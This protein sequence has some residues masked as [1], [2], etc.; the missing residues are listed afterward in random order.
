MRSTLSAVLLA[1]VFTRYIEVIMLT[2]SV[3]GTALTKGKELGLGVVRAVD[4][5][6]LNSSPKPFRN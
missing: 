5:A 3:I 1:M 6:F 4:G 2:C